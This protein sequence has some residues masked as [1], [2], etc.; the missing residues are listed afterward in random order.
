MLHNSSKLWAMTGPIKLTDKVSEII[1]Q[2][3]RAGLP[4][5]R[6]AAMAG[7]NRITAWRWETQGATEIDQVGDDD[8]AVLSP[9]AIFS[10]AFGQARAAYLAELN[11]AWKSAIAGKDSNR[12]KAIQT[13]LA[14]VSPDEFSERRATRTIDQ[15]TTMSGD[16]TVGRFD[17]MSDDDLHAE[18]E[19]ILARRD[20][21]KAGAGADCWQSA[22][23]RTPHQGT[24]EDQPERAAGE[25]NS[26]VKKR[27]SG[28]RNRK[29]GTAT[30]GFGDHDLAEKI[31]PTRARTSDASVVDGP[32]GVQTDGTAPEH[33]GEGG[34]SVA[35]APP[36][37]PFPTSADDDEE[38]KL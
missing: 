30:K 21:D 2:H 24:E 12:A 36:S 3:A 19:K 7:V 38:V 18:R 29:P 28:S 20:A 22:A 27:Q 35:G 8:D 34:V 16:V 4:L 26:T 9:R 23:V 1:C 33:A 5:R 11:A 14:A 37:P 31:S 32:S 17:A 10:L 6:A 13:M 15:H 25:N